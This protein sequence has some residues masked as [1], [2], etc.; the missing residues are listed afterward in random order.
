MLAHAAAKGTSFFG[1]GSVARKLRTKDMERIRGGVGL[2][3]WSGPM[4]VAAMLGLSALPP[5]GTFRSE[6][7]IVAGGLAGGQGA[8]SAEQAVAAV[9]VVLA[10]LGFLG[11][12]WHITQ[13][14]LSPGPDQVAMG[15]P[16]EMSVTKGETS[17][18][19]VLAMALGLVGLVVLGARP[20]RRSTTSSTVPPPSS[21]RGHDRP[22]PDGRPRTPAGVPRFGRRS[23][24]PPA[25]RRRGL[26]PA[27]PWPVARLTTD[28]RFAGLFG[29]AQSDGSVR[30]R[31]VIAHFGWL[32]VLSCYLPSAPEGGQASYQALTPMVPSATWYERELADMFGLVPEG[33]PTRRPIGPP[34]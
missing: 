6:L 29:S 24:L 30:L 9:L 10:T 19:M 2:L 11:L 26:S 25:H 4:L 34:P 32:E 27:S 31:A 15:A 28:G 20:R 14:M 13:T 18:L 3:P 17:K 21:G 12:S 33:H 5:F 16:G 7:A 1:A 23:T 22:C 8:N